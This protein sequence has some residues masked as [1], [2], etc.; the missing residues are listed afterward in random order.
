MQGMRAWLLLLGLICSGALAQSALELEVLQRTN[1]VRLER[2]LRPLQWDALAYKAAL[3][4]ARDML[5]RNYFAH[6]NPD[7]LGAAERMQVAGVLEVTNGE[8]LASFEGYP[9]PEIPQRSLTGWMNSPGHRANLLKPEFTH[10]GV[11]LVRQGRRVMV[12]Q[13]FIGRPFDPQISLS[14]AQAERNVLV[15]SGTA[16]GTVGIFVGNNLYARLNPPIQARLEL[17]PKS[18]VSFAVFDGRTWWTTRNGQRG[19]RLESTLER[20]TVPGKQV[21]LNLPAGTFTLAVGSQPRFWQ[22]VSGPV[23]LELTLPGTLEALWLGLRRDT[24]VNYSH[25]IPLKP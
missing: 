3:G 19:L 21:I 25:R 7:G 6:Q 4:H 24:S 16:S 22:N 15:V 14:P 1:Q 2:G 17:P 5:E 10:L 12:V 8:N 13:N 20:S 18:E 9:D 11:A 23:R